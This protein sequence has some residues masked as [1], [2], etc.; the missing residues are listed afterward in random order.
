M[1]APDLKKMIDSMKSAEDGAI[2]TIAAALV[3]T[4]V[5]VGKVSI[6]PSSAMPLTGVLIHVHPKVYER[7]QQWKGEKP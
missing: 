2:T 7:L 1:S 3:E 5:A 4:T 6:M